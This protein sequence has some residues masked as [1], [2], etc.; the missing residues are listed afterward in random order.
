[1][2]RTKASSYSK[3]GSNGYGGYMYD[4]DMNKVEFSGYRADAVTDF[5]L[6]YLQNRD[7]TNPFFLFLSYIEPHHQ[8]DRNRYEGPKGSKERFNGFEVPGD[9]VDTEGDWRENYPDYLGCCASIDWNVGRLREELKRQGIAK[10]TVIVYTSDHGSH[11]KTR[12]SEYKRSCHEGSIRIPLLAYG[13]GFEGGRIV[14]ELVSSIDIPPTLL[15]CGDIDK[16]QTMRGRCLQ[17]LVNG[18]D[19]DWPQEVYIQISESQVGR[20]IRTKRWKYSVCAISKD[21]W[22][23]SCSEYRDVCDKLMSILKRRMIEAGEKGAK[24]IKVEN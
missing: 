16:P 21:G 12:N 11:F 9:L 17:E 1:M 23:D 3:L 22:N 8:N 13:P 7:K 2:L 15:A 19:V 24:I 18:K 14:H 5:A 4:K 6:D 10:D 20:A